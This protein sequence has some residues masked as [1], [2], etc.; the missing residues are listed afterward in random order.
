MRINLSVCTVRRCDI[1]RTTQKE[2]ETVLKKDLKGTTYTLEELEEAILA[3]R[4]SKGIKVA[5]STIY[6]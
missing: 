2:L 3:H 4:A 5:D 6:R 1:L